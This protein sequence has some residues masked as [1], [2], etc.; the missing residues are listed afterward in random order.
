MASILGISEHRKVIESSRHDIFSALDEA[1]AIIKE[2][3]ELFD[4]LL[5]DA[6]WSN[7]DSRRFKRHYE[8]G[9]KALT[10]S[11]EELNVKALGR[12]LDADEEYKALEEEV[13]NL[14]AD[15]FWKDA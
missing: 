11:I 1:N 5:T 10:K 9:H 3:K 13:K 15:S 2:M 4:N 12:L 6:Q 7:H 14:F 8:D